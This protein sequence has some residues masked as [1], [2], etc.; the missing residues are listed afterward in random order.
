MQESCQLVKCC[1]SEEY[2]NALTGYSVGSILLA[3]GTM[4]I[5]DMTT[6][7]LQSFADLVYR[8][9]LKDLHRVGLLLDFEYNTAV[10]SFAPIVMGNKGWR[11]VLEALKINNDDTDGKSSFTVKLAKVSL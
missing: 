7:D 6:E 9:T 10:S 3:M 4:T 11:R 1:R 8:S 2:T 5:Y